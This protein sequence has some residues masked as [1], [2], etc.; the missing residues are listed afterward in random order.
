[1]NHAHFARALR[2]IALFAAPLLLLGAFALSEAAYQGT[3]TRD[4]T[5]RKTQSTS[6]KKLGSV[7]KGDT[8]QIVSFDKTWALIETPEATGYILAK[9]ID[10]LRAIGPYDD[11]AS[12]AYLGMAKKDLTVRATQDKAGLRLQSL[13]AGETVYIQELGK[14]W[15]TVVKNG[16]TG[17]VLASG[18]GELRGAREGI[19]LPE[20]YTTPVP[21]VTTYTA[22][23]A[24]NLN[25]RKNPDANAPSRGL[26]NENET[27][28]IMDIEG[29][30]AHVKKGRTEGYVLSEHLRHFRRTDPF[31]PTIP[32]VDA[33]L[34]ALVSASELTLVNPQT[35]ERLAQIPAGVPFAGHEPGAD[36]TLTLPYH[37]LI[38]QAQG[39]ADLSIERTV[40]WQQAQ[41]GELI[42]AFSTFFNPLPADEIEQGR[43]FN[44][45]EGVRRVD[46]AVMAPGEVFSFNALCAPYT[47]GN[48]YA[49]GP[50]VNFVSSEKTGYSGGI[51]QVSTTLYNAALQVPIEIVSQR[52]HSSYGIFYVPLDMDA[53]VGAGNMDLRLRN[54]LHYPVRI[55]AETQGGVLTIRLYREG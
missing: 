26:V 42:A 19:E 15:H 14:S 47:K 4:M 5:I 38:A 12:A 46:Q 53:A 43:I 7:Q 33:S 17:F 51:C 9:N 41:P 50:I 16:L 29:G 55:A 22:V 10:D 39:A 20:A 31:G 6:G 32:G 28:N 1:M 37:Q 40:S 54:A 44:I 52:V 45:Q 36:G 27:V 35:G 3:V 2:R 11:A 30:W 49:L 8:V 21:F 13:E 18:V 24:I 23:A 25:L 34:Q 48:G